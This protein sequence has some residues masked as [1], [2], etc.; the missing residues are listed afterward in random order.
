MAKDQ[1]PKG[2]GMRLKN[3]D[4]MVAK[5]K[6]L[7][8]TRVAAVREACGRLVGQGEAVTTSAVAREAR[9]PRKSLERA[10]YS[11]LISRYRTLMAP[12]KK[13]V[14]AEVAAIQ[15]ELQYWKAIVEKYRAEN[16]ALLTL[17]AERGVLVPADR[18]V[19]K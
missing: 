16:A 18:R 15:Q 11:L 17:L 4:A 19:K 5:K 7:V 9:I 8:N 3:T 14:P 1:D 12:S 13:D 10:P 2:N 6:E